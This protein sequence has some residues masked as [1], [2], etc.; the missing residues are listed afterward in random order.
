MKNK[1]YKTN[2]VLENQRKTKC[3]I[4]G[5]DTKCCLEFHH[6]R[7]KLYNISQSVKFLP[8][9]LFKKELDK[10]VCICSNC[11]KKLHTGLIT[12]DGN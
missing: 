12:L 2:K 10:C 3:I 6:L 5:E 11:H 4:C 7:N 9:N 8:P 1:Y